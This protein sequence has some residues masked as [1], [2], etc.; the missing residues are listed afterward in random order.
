MFYC[1]EKRTL[2]YAIS[3]LENLILDVEK[4]P[5][6]LPWCEKIKIL[7]KNYN[8]FEADLLISY[9]KIKKSYISKTEIEKDGDYIRIVTNSND[10]LF[11]NLHSSWRLEKISNNKTLIKFQIYFELKSVFFNKILGLFFKNAN[12]KM[13]SS[14]EKRAQTMIS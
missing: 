4:Y 5:E 12:Q 10:G 2:P 3:D 13:I 8:G 6:F 1:Q 14:F 11:K 9:K 7:K